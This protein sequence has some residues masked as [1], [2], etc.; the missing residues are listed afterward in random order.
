MTIGIILHP[1]GEDSPAGL[2]RIIFE[3]TKWMLS[4]DSVN[5]YLIFLKEKPKLPLPFYS[6]RWKMEILG[7]GYFWLERLRYAS[8]ADV[9]I[10]NTPVMPF[11]FRPR[12][13]VVIVLDFAYKYFNVR[14]WREILLNFLLTKYHKFSLKRADAIVAI[15]NATKKD[16]VSFFGIPENKISIIYPGFN[17]I[18]EMGSKEKMPLPEKFFLFVGVLKERKNVLNVI[19]AFNEFR[20]KHNGFSLVIAGKARGHYFETIKS[21]VRDNSLERDVLFQGYLSDGELAVLYKKAE[22]LVFPSMV[23]GFGF[24]VLE[25]MHCGLPVITSNVSSL[26]ELGANKAA[27]LVNPESVR[28]IAEAMSRVVI[29]KDFRQNLI[30][31]GF[32]QA[33]RFSWDKSAQ[34]MFALLSK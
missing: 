18:C 1:Y 5:D 27:I 32:K 17:R 4:T 13:T 21:F 19:K 16:V 2:S 8:H 31:N 10:F 26:A 9:Y 14:N 22:A 3:L 28:E 7:S 15:S 30:D 34:E 12:K 6:G 29:D 33:E 23:E 20:K 11:F 25:A 24:P